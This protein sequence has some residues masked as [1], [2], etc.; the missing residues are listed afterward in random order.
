MLARSVT[1]GRVMGVDLSRGMLE[2]AKKRCARC[3]NVFLT[4]SDAVAF[5]STFD[6]SSVHGIVCSFGLLYLDQRAF[7]DEAARVIRKGGFIAVL[8]NRADTLSE[9]MRVFKE[10]LLAQPLSLGKAV[11]VRMPSDAKYVAQQMQ[12]RGFDIRSAQDDEFDVPAA[13]G[14]DVMA[15]LEKAAVG[16]GYFDAITP[17]RR[18]AFQRYFID[19]W[20]S[21]PKPLNVRHSVCEVI[22]VKL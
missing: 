10:T 11:R 1:T 14:K 20:N 6:V 22:G 16:A 4:C 9:V 21:S 7:F 15:Y 12:M 3:N 13:S 17:A 2:Q 8:E 18:E 19:A 5:L